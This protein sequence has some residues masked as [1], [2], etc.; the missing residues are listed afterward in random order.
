M[1]KN[2]TGAR[3]MWRGLPAVGLLR[4]GQ[5]AQREQLVPSGCASD[6]DRGVWLRGPHLPGL[7]GPFP[8]SVILH[9]WSKLSGQTGNTNLHRTG[10][11]SP[12]SVFSGAREQVPAA[13]FPRETFRA[14]PLMARLPT[15][16]SSR[17]GW[18]C[19]SSPRPAQAV[20]SSF[21]HLAQPRQEST[22]FH[23][24][25]LWSFSYV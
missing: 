20:M 18:L 3:E 7:K 25:T 11:R 23:E 24:H 8:N 15:R 4:S 19:T 17:P 10:A 1:D 13:P 21:I 5:L 2:I 12:S 6:P 22:S 16:V 14:P 9:S